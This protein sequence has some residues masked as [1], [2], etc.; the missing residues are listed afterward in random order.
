MS[1]NNLFFI[2]R[3]AAAKREHV[4]TELEELEKEENDELKEMEEVDELIRNVQADEKSR[5]KK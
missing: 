1:H 2:F 4:P 3:A 5:M